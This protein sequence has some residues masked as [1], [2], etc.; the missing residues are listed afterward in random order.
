MTKHMSSFGADELISY[1]DSVYAADLL[2]A[3]IGHLDFFSKLDEFPSNLVGILNK[4]QL[5]DRP[6]DVMLTLFK[7]MGLIELKKDKYRVTN[8]A[9]EY[10]TRNSGHSLVPYYSTLTERSEVSKILEVLRTGKPAGW[11][12]KRKEEELTLAMERDD[13]AEMFTSGMDS[14]GAYLAPVL[15][16]SFDFSKYKSILD[17]A[18]GSGIYA[19]TIK[20]RH[21]SIRAGL[22][23]KSPVDRIVTRGLKK[24][25]QAGLLQVFEADMFAENF[26]DGFDIHLYSHVLHDWDYKEIKILLDKSFQSLNPGGIVMIHDT[27]LNK[28]KKGPLSVAEYSVLVMYAT[29]GKCYSLG[30]MEELLTSAG[31]EDIDFGITGGNRSIITGLKKSKDSS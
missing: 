23:E 22:L 16:E 18:G 4:F 15:A 28:D 21:P 5:K 27:H 29:E 30:E 24:K 17:I 3:A 11:S 10:L 6:A 14:R 19:I 9:K 25:G 20:N 13:F 8:L 1:R 26:P 2:I 31:F 12:G 7:S